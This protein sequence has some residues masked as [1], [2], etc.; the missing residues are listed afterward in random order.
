MTHIGAEWDW[1]YWN[2]VAHESRHD[3]LDQMAVSVN[4]V[5]FLGVLMTRALLF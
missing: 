1:Q 4:W 2:S 5:D 3:D